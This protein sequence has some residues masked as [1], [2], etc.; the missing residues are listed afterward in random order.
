MCFG[1]LC[2]YIQTHTCWS[3]THKK[4]NYL[5]IWMCEIRSLKF[6]H[7]VFLSGQTWV[8][9]L[10]SALTTSL[11]PVVQHMSL[12]SQR[13]HHQAESSHRRSALTSP[14]H[15]LA[16]SSVTQSHIKLFIIL[17]CMGHTKIRR[18]HG[19]HGTDFIGCRRGE[20]GPLALLINVLTNTAA[21][22]LSLW[23]S[24][25]THRPIFIAFR[26]L[27]VVPTL[28]VSICCSLRLHCG[29][30]SKK[31][32]LY[33]CRRTVTPGNDG[34]FTYGTLRLLDS[35]PTV[36]SFRLLDTSTTGHFAY[37]TFC[38]LDSSSIGQFGY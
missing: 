28:L 37:E 1:P 16:P 11:V 2:M 4:Q 14:H 22:I 27:F 7:M 32:G 34:H 33:F 36:W 19:T 12:M 20:G 35:S 25:Y 31:Q 5:H 15:Q 38:L 26:L 17:H 10:D 6:L 8:A 3:I 18:H 30:K 23:T 24:H 13:L 29:H 21:R 9:R